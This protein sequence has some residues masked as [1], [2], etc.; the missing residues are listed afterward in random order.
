MKL[1]LPHISYAIEMGISG[2][3]LLIF[4]HVTEFLKVDWSYQTSHC[5]LVNG[6]HMYICI[7][8]FAILP[9]DYPSL[10]PSY[11]I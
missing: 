6:C 1:K 3:G 10:L 4:L 11:L 9:H 7:N 5:P 8:K 2:E